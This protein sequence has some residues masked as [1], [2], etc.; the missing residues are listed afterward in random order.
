M[1]GYRG[2]KCRFTV[3]AQTGAILQEGYIP[4]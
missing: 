2:T 3:D 1:V 4:R